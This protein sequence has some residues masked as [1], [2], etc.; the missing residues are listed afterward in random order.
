MNTALAA[1]A[2]IPAVSVLAPLAAGAAFSTVAHRAAVGPFT[3]AL[4]PAGA[5]S[6]VALMLV[7]VGAQISPRTLGPVSSRVAV[8]LAGAT[9]VPAAAVAAYWRWCGPA[10]IA[11]VSVLAAAA[12]AVCTS[13]A[14][15][16][17]LAARYGSPA[18][19]WGGTVAAAINSGP[20]LPLLLLTAGHPGA[21]PWLALAD[22]V[23][24]LAVGFAVGLC[25]DTVRVACRGAIPALMVAFSFQLGARLNLAGLAAQ[26]PAGATLGAAVAVLSG[27]AVAV[28][29]RLLLHEPAAVGWAS[30]AV[31]IGAPIVPVVVA[32]ALPAWQPYVPAAVAQV[33]VAVLVSSVA[34]T[35]LCALAARRRPARPAAVAAPEPSPTPQLVSR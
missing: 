25:G 5:L 21:T 17:A 15:W 34:A 29:Y 20:V 11:G 6:T 14:V 8:I 10:G 2:K 32:Q 13:T 18:D 16:L 26:A 22:A 27:A 28:G 1:A 30:G 35:A 23:A 12:A 9:L 4:G 3:V 19:R 7:C 31:T 24:P 33:G